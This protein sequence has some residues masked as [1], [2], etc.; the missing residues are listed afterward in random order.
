MKVHAYEKAML[1]VGAAI[2]VA[3]GA[4]LIYASLAM[5]LHLPGKAGFIEPQRVYQTAPFN[6]P[7]V[8]EIAPGRYEAA[9]VAQTWAFIP[10]EIRVPAGAEVTFNVTS[11]DILHGF[12]IEGTR[13]NMMLI[14]G[15][16]SRNSYTFD[17]PGEY[18][19]IC[20]EYCGLGHHTMAG[21][22]IVEAP[23]V[24]NVARSESDAAG[25]AR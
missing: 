12:N 11:I 13:L 16:V 10:R 25:T 2:L 22:I 18:L 5:N 23:R 8:R 21:K 20:H 17:R 7:G 19:I 4:A 15:Q 3:C 6:R 14:P 1:V 9:I 24:A